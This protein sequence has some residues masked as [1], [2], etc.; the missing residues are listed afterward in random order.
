[1]TSD[2]IDPIPSLFIRKIF[3]LVSKYSPTHLPVVKLH[4]IIRCIRRQ[5]S[6]QI[7]CMH[8]YTDSVS[9]Y[10]TTTRLASA[11]Y[12]HTGDRHDAACPSMGARS[13]GHSL[14][15]RASL[16]TEYIQTHRVPTCRR[17]DLRS[18]KPRKHASPKSIFFVFF[19]MRSYYVCTEYPRKREN[20]WR[21]PWVLPW[22]PDQP[23]QVTHDGSVMSCH[24]RLSVNDLRESRL[25]S[26]WLLAGDLSVWSV[27]R[28]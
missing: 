18:W 28:Y 12:I 23:K 8:R 3:N 9:G 2:L 5:A 6:K 11:P 14:N 15:H 16:S 13:G 4:A 20:D 7:P 1:M 10:S 17:C 27:P 21:W 26:L 22:L 24:G 19:F 25:T